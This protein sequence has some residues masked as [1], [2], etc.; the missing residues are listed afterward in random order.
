MTTEKI[1]KN[2]EFFKPETCIYLN[3][4]LEEKYRPSPEKE[5]VC[6]EN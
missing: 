1:K 2:L 5:E 6:T 4:F 3:F